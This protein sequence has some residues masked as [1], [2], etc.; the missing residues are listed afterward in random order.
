[1]YGD[2]DSQLPSLLKRAFFFF[3]NFI[4]QDSLNTLVA[5]T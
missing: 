5:T 3:Y 2:K 1:V 4:V